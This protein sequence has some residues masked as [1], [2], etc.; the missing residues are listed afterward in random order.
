MKQDFSRP[1]ESR[2][3]GHRIVSTRPMDVALP[4]ARR[5][6]VLRTLFACL[7]LIAATACS[8]TQAEQDD[9]VPVQVRGLNYTDIPIGVFYVEDRWAGNVGSY[10]GGGGT[11]TSYGVPAVW[12]PGLKVR[13]DWRNDLLYRKDKK[14]LTT[15][16]VEIPPYDRSI[17]YLWVAFLPC[18]R[19]KV[20]VS[21]TSP[22]FPG[23]PNTALINPREYCRK[24]ARCRAKFI[25]GPQIIYDEDR[26]Q[27]N[28]DQEA[29][30]AAACQAVKEGTSPL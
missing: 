5:A 26:P 18:D 2:S 7:L 22:G 30:Q 21:N 9:M 6:T 3:S 29:W 28:R 14:A 16:I 15:S 13:I 24:D 4:T 25:D 10:N 11:A 8:R 19:I 20:Y 1:L 27:W 17:S 12:R 23:F